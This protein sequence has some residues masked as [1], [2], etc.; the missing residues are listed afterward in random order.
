VLFRGEL[1]RLIGRLQSKAEKRGGF[2]VGIR[3]IGIPGGL[4]GFPGLLVSSELGE[5]RQSL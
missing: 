1:G 4:E 2:A 3:G 5:E